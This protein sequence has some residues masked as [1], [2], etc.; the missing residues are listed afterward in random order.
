MDMQQFDRFALK[1]YS[2]AN[3]CEECCADCSNC[4]LT[5]VPD[6]LSLNDYILNHLGDN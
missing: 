1:N 2:S 4:P 5:V 6:S 3:P